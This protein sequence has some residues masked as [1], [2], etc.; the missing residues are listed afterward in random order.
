MGLTTNAEKKREI[1]WNVI[2]VPFTQTHAAVR[3]ENLSKV[4]Q[5]YHYHYDK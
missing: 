5:H 3:Y 2:N 4:K 1:N